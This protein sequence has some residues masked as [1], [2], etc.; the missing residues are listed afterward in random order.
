M[1][2]VTHPHNQ[3]PSAIE[4]TGSRGVRVRTNTQGRESGIFFKWLS[5]WCWYIMKSG[6][7]WEGYRILL[8]SCKSAMMQLQIKGTV[9]KC[10]GRWASE[11]CE[12]RCCRAQA[13]P[14]P[15]EE[16][17]SWA[18]HMNR[19]RKLYWTLS[20]FARPKQVLHSLT[21]L[22]LGPL[23]GVAGI[24]SL[25]LCAQ[26]KLKS[27]EKFNTS[28]PAPKYHPGLWVSNEQRQHSANMLR[29]MLHTKRRTKYNT[30]VPEACECREPLTL[31]TSHGKTKQ[32]PH[33]AGSRSMQRY[34]SARTGWGHAE[35][36]RGGTAMQKQHPPA[37]SGSCSL[38]SP[39]LPAQFARVHPAMPPLLGSKRCDCWFLQLRTA[40]VCTAC[41]SIS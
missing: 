28:F 10:R 32:L 4:V 16:G 5:F 17:N 6:P 18:Q 26:P 8:E 7:N 31:N 29:S 24:K 9:S 25:P 11:R 12:L 35:Y 27:L 1:Q 40:W 20:G 3:L 14:W 34:S 15:R 21:L 30:R 2:L 36:W 39:A 13:L 19:A 41:L 23:E 33:T 37:N 38:S 22:L